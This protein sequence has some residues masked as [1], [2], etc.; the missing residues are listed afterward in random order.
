MDGWEELGW[1][2]L[3]DQ[4]PRNLCV[5]GI[6]KALWSRAKPRVDVCQRSGDVGWRSIGLGAVG[7]KWKWKKAFVRH[8]CGG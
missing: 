2:G 1:D 3:T 5:G 6:Y 7:R 8:G 4:T